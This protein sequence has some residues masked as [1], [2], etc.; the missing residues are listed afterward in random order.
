MKQ[1]Q[2]NDSTGDEGD[3]TYD[4]DNFDE[5]EVEMGD[6]PYNSENVHEG[7]NIDV[8]FNDEFNMEDN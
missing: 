2:Q 6:D 3:G 5:T 4:P 7:D 8:H 1:A